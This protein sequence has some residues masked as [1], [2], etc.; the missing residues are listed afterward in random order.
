MTGN[1]LLKYMIRI[2]PTE[3]KKSSLVYHEQRHDGVSSTTFRFDKSLSTYDAGLY[4]SNPQ[5][6]RREDKRAVLYH[7]RLQTKRDVI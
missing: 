3:N 2:E 7:N 6:Y 1:T 5:M 4:I